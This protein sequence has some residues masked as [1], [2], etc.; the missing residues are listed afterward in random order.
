MM[1]I[2]TIM[3]RF[4]APP[5][6]VPASAVDRP[7]RDERAERERLEAALR[8]SQALAEQRLAEVEAVYRSA[9]IGLCVMDADLRYIRINERLAAIN[10]VP[11]AAHLGRSLWEIVP[12]L[13]DD[14]APSY[15][16]VLATGEPLLDVEI[17]GRTAGRP[18]GEGHWIVS[19]YPLKAPG[20]RVIAVNVAVSDITERKRIEDALRES[21]QRF[22]AFMN[23]SPTPAFLKDADGRYVYINPAATAVGGRTPA[24][25]IG[26]RDA[27][28]FGGEEARR[29]EEN[30]RAVLATGRS[31]EFSEVIPGKRGRRHFQ[32]IKFRIDA[33]ERSYLGG[34]SLDVTEQHRAEA[35]REKL[36]E[37]E[38]AAR[39]EAERANRM[40]DEFLAMLS[41]ELRTPLNA[42]LGYTQM[43]QSGVI[44]A[45]GAARALEIIERNARV[46][47]EII[48]DLLDMNRIVTGKLR[49][50]LAPA[51]LAAI[52]DAAVA[53]IRQS[54]EQKGLGL[55]VDVTPL[56]RPVAGDGA[57]LQQVLW[58]LL[59]N[60]VKFTPRGGRVALTV[61]A[62]GE[63]VEIRVADTGQ[64]IDADLL[65]RVFDRFWQAD[66]STSRQHR[67]LGLGL[68][69]TKQLV[70]LHG[71]TIRAESP[72]PGGGTT[73][74]V[75][76]PT[77][78][79]GCD[80][81][82]CARAAAAEARSTLAGV[83]A[84]VVDDEPDA[85]ALVRE[86]LEAR[87]ASVRAVASAAEALAAVEAEVPEVIVSDIGMPV[88]DGYALIRK[89][90]SLPPERGGLVPAVA[91]TAF[92]R[93]EDR[94]RAREAGYQDHL[95]KPL[96]ASAL[97]AAVTALVAPGAGRG[98]G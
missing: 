98:G 81:Q 30:D 58:N 66:S 70:E 93:V 69:I 63:A 14:V 3:A 22:T 52:A 87:G 21:E 72:G 29:V 15:R 55:D 92:A 33:P 78:D 25:V 50:D 73:M 45:E 43:L 61:R 37:A 1:P 67:G 74:T 8:E 13:A 62:A 83:K 4:E 2:R 24:E 18:D 95:A 88:E 91:L 89:L 7:E 94:E 38:R 20:G 68:A 35:D 41:H 57:R 12:D 40:K 39:G 11:A 54:A 31:M 6:E 77:A 85:R 86:L 36:L 16:R 80:M 44:R 47:I 59:T 64:G 60:A 65:P 28:F 56:P 27:D 97:Y 71:G 9:P 96:D 51:D 48:S 79:P 82:V 17:T 75:T 46:Q 32:S 90:R 10:G 53:S 23:N 84:L 26:K 34:I 76:L 19:F 49:L 42:V 5:I